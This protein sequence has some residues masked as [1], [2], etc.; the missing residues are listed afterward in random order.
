MAEAP[1]EDFLKSM[2]QG[3]I[4]GY[5]P[6]FHEVWIKPAK[7]KN[8]EEKTRLLNFLR[9]IEDGEVAA[10][11]KLLPHIDVNLE[12]NVDGRKNES[13]LEW[14]VEKA[15][16]PEV[17]RLL[18]KAGAEAKGKWL[19]YKAVSY[20]GNEVL[21]ELLAAGA[22]P[23]AGS[24]DEKPLTN[25]CFRDAEAVR[26]LLKSGARTDIGAT[27]YVT[28]NRPVKKVTP[29]MIA[30]YAGQ[31]EIAKLLL[32][33]GAD[34]KAKDEKGNT[35]V[36]WAKISREKKKAAKI[37]EILEGEGVSE[38]ASKKGNL[39]EPA[40][41][42][43][44]A[45]EPDFKS[46]LGLAKQVT[47]SSPKV[48]ELELGEVEGA[49]AFKVGDEKKALEILKEIR[50]KVAA[51]GAYAFLSEGL[52]EFNPTYL[53]LVPDRDYT[54]AIVAFETPVGQSVDCHDLN[55]WLKKLEEKE[56]FEITHIAP[57]LVRARFKGKLKDSKWVAKQMHAICSDAMDSPVAS[58]AKRLEES[59]ELF[60]WW[61]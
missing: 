9:A 53:V 16:N 57:D 56:P 12:L 30:A 47:K 20:G 24:P 3:W 39:P 60:L 41:F 45:K 28:N 43:E 6:W 17:I 49:R 54:K 37:I 46:A 1:D 26:L 18:L 29:L 4:A 38:S 32:E 22:D 2:Q 61:D 42:S 23:N 19:A 40:D 14:A 34:P 50:P 11:K 5:P 35:A 44:A 10:M 52:F 48:I 7:C 58:L 55:K 31:P 13:L 15:R 25:A 59:G 27:I 33:A 51:L 8:K 36:A 21:A